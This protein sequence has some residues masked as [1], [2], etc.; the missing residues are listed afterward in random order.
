MYQATAAGTSSAQR[1]SVANPRRLID[2]SFPRRCVLRWTLSALVE[3]PVP[4]CVQTEEMLETSVR[5][6]RLLSL[7]QVRR[8]WSGAD[9]AEPPRG[10]HQDRAQRRRTAAHPRLRGALQHR[11]HRRLPA[12]GRFRDAAAA[13]RRR[14]GRRRRGGAARRGGRHGHRDRGDLAA[15]ADQAR[16]DPAGPAAAPARRPAPGHR[17]RGGRRADR[18]RRDAHDHRRRLPR[19]RAAALRLPRAATAR[20]AHAGSSRTASSTPVTAGTCSRGTA[21]ARTGARS[22]PTA[23]GRA[24]PPGHGSRRGSRPRTPRATSY[25]GPARWPG[26]IRRGSACT[27]PPRSSPRTNAHAGGRPAAPCRRAQLRPGDRQRLAA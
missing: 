18:R 24:C 12:R 20:P 1:L 15:S 23:S 19:P 3:P 26:R 13:A 5:L 14:R 6:L 27:R 2:A 16:T 4:Q 25:A 22:G 7:L 8:D 9:L 17:L 10:H 21:T 11:D